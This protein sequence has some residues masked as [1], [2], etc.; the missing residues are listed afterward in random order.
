MEKRPRSGLRAPSVHVC[1]PR[2]GAVPTADVEPMAPAGF[3]RF[4]F[5]ALLALLAGLLA[6]LFAA[7]RDLASPQE[8]YLAL[9]FWLRCNGNTLVSSDRCWENLP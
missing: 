3:A 6:L 4:A 5:L 7:P 2:S 1:V 8:H 9:A